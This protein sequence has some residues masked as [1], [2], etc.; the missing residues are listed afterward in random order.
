MT[1]TSMTT[2]LFKWAQ[3]IGILTV[4][5]VWWFVAGWTAIIIG[6]GSIIKNRITDTWRKHDHQSKIIQR[7]GH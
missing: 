1:T 4:W 5:A 3:V 7:L 6:C 2:F